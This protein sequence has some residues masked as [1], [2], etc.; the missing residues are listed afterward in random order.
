MFSNAG[1]YIKLLPL[2]GALLIAMIPR[3][4]PWARRGCPF[5]AQGDELGVG[6]AAFS[7]Y[8]NQCCMLLQA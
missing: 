8:S 6:K 1:Q 3:A 4:L 5:R 2:Q 7:R